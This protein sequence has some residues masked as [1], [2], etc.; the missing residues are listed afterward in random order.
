MPAFAEFVTREAARMRADDT[1]AFTENQSPVSPSNVVDFR[2]LLQRSRAQREL[3][4]VPPDADMRELRA[5]EFGNKIADGSS[6]GGQMVSVAGNGGRI[7]GGGGAPLSEWDAPPEIP[8]E[9]LD[10]EVPEIPDLHVPDLHEDVG[11]DLDE[12]LRSNGSARPL[13]TAAVSKIQWTEEQLAALDRIDEWFDSGDSFF[14]LTGPAGSGKST[15]VNEICRRHYSAVLAA[16]TGK[17]ALRLSACAEREAT[18]L[19][20]ILYWPPNPGEDLRFTRLREPESDFYIVDEC[21]VGS[22][23]IFTE[24]G[25]MKIGKIVNAKMPIRVWSRNSATGDLELKPIV[26]W[27]KRPAPSEMLQINVGRTNSKRDGRLIRC[28]KEHK[29]MTPSGYVR[30]SDLRVGDELV[31]R[32]KALTKEQRSVLIGSL[33]GD[34][35]TTREGHVRTSAQAKFIQ[36]EDQLDYL[37][38]KKGVFGELASELKSY[39]SGFENGKPVWNFSIA[40]TDEGTAIAAETIYNGKVYKSGRYQWS[41][42]D[43]FLSMLDEQA[44]AVWFLDNGSLAERRNGSSIHSERFNLADHKRFVVLLHERF[45]IEAQI[46]EARGDMVHLRFRKEAT[47]RLLAIVQKYTPDCM[48]WKVGAACDY[49]YSAP[50]HQ[51]QT[52]V[53]RVREISMFNPAT[54]RRPNPSV[55]DIEVADF[56]NYVAGNVVVSNC[57]MTSPTVFK[58]L[59]QWADGGVRILLV[60]DSFQLPPVITGEELKEYGEDFSVFSKVDGVALETVMR[61]AGGVLRAAKKVRETGEICRESDEGYEYLRSQTPTMDAVN[62]YLA[63]PDDHMVITWRNSVRMTA[64]KIIRERLGHAGPLPDEGERVLLKKNGQGFMNGEIVECG[65][66][67]TGPVVGGMRTLWMTVKDGPRILVSFDGGK[68]GERMDGGACWV[69][70]YKKYHIDLTKN[71]LPEPIPIT[72]SYVVTAHAG[73][74]SEARRVTV[75]LEREDTRNRNFKKL[76]TLPGGR[77]VTLACRWSYT[78]TTRSKVRSTMIVGR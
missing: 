57:S 67:K 12:W 55:Y 11:D 19:H 34:G 24:N 36:G 62:A 23:M 18:T 47:E 15:I 43:R 61:S 51:T 6:F 14:A 17:A 26:R 56:H 32:G 70:N 71:A 66:F 54:K 25:W 21:F 42:T 49:S 38:F 53:A 74:G 40:V 39:P 65:S 78:A 2:K 77:Q 46:Q 33:L 27:L 59:K 16:M 73:Q 41:P 60:G 72:W 1:S 37:K 63:D 68:D 45:G 48:S 44:L 28:T 31:V 9:L 75:F 7:V 3:T 30:A 5:S 69:E 20:K 4:V 64:N 22:Q 13:P 76:T 10:E 52:T 58:H 8:D 35:S 29:I 50:P